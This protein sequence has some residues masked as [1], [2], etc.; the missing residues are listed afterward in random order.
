MAPLT[1]LL[2][3]GRQDLLVTEKQFH[4]N[5]KKYGKWK[6]VKK[7]EGD[8]TVVSNVMALLTPYSRLAD[9]TSTSQSRDCIAIPRKTACGK[10]CKHLSAKQRSEQTL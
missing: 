4:N 8:P 9:Q 7:C 5:P 10:L 6:L 1:L 3:L 2:K